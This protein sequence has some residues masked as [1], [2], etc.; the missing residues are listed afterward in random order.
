M[1][2]SQNSQKK[3][4]NVLLSLEWDHGK[5]RH[6]KASP[7]K[8]HLYWLLTWHGQPFRNQ[9]PVAVD[10]KGHYHANWINR[11][12]VLKQQRCHKW[13]IWDR[14]AISLAISGI[15]ANCLTASISGLLKSI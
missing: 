13:V 11:L 10:Q 8:Q 3:K 7:I 14:E 4:K 15:A 1:F 9:P 12:I 5:S 6:Q 2:D